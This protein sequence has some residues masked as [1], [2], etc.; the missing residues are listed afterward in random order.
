MQVV[1]N[2]HMIGRRNPE[3]VLQ[4]N[5]YLRTF[6][7]GGSA[8][9][10]WCVDPGSQ[11]DYPVIRENLLRR[12]GEFSALDLISLNHQ[13]PDVTGNLIPFTKE[14]ARLA[15][16]VTEDSWRLIRHLNAPPQHLWFANRMKRNLLDL[17]GGHRLQ[18]VPT[19]FCHFRGAMAFYDLE[20]QVLFSGDLFGG[21]NVPGRVHLFAQEDDWLGIA[22]FH[23]IYMPSREV[24]SYSVRQIRAL[25]PPVKIIAPQHG[26]VLAGDFM[27][28][29]MDRLDHLAMGMDLLPDELDERYLQGYAEVFQEIV[30]EAAQRL[31]RAEV[32]SLLQ[33]LPADH[34][35]AECLRVTDGE[36]R[37]LRKGIRALPLLA[38]VLTRHKLPFL[39]ELFKE[40]VLRACLERQV[41]LPQMGVGVEELGAELAGHW[42]G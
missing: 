33:H 28:Q 35:L 26:F 14:N 8:R 13:D 36:V 3:S 25:D 40:R 17:P 37:L 19:P 4:C 6:Q 32:V 20:T 42:F 2:C 1:E 27:H 7:G 23:Q 16:L 41:P 22:Q 9:L 39:R 15:A 12:L 10:H 30:D 21:L 24:V 18:M 34:E 5:T 11:I 29:V 38:D 31:G